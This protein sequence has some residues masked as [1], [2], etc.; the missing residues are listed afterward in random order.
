MEVG[1]IAPSNEERGVEKAMD[2][3]L[4][5]IG[6]HRKKIAKDGSC[7]FRAVAEQVLHCQSLHTEVRAKCVEFLKQNRESYEAFIE[8]DFEEYLFKLQDPQQWV[9]EVEINALAVMYKRDFLIFQEPG[10]P[11]VNITDNNF[12]DKV[13][14]CFLNGNHYD[15]VYPISHI[16]NTAV[17]QSILYELLYDGVFKVDRSF[18][19]LC[20]RTSRPTDLLSDD[21]MLACASS[22]ES[23]LDAGDALWVENGTSSASTRHGSHTYR[24]RGRG[25]QLPERVRR[26]LNP[27]LL[28]NIEYDVWQKSKRAQQKMDYCIAAGMHFSVGDRCQVRLD[29]SGRSYGATIKEVPPNNGPVTVYI[30]ELGRKHTVSLWSLRPP[31]DGGSWSTVSNRDK[32]LSNGHG[33]WEEK[34]RGRGKAPPGASSVST[35]TA[36][37]ATGRVQKQHSWPPPT[38][39]DE[40]GATKPTRKSVSSAESAFGL[41]EEQRLAKEEEK[42]NVALVEIQLRDELSFPALGTQSEGGKRKGGEKRR[43]Q[44]NKTKSPVEDVRAPS[45]KSSTPPPPTSPPPET[46][47]TNSASPG[48][49]A[50]TWLSSIKAS[51]SSQSYASAAGPAA[52]PAV[53]PPPFITPVLPPASSSSPP[54]TFIAPIA[55]PPSSAQGLPQ[56]SPSPPSVQEAPAAQSTNP[57]PKPGVTVT[58]SQTVQRQNQDTQ[59]HIA[60]NQT[61]RSQNQV[62][63]TQTSVPQTQDQNQ[64]SVHQ[65][66]NQTSVHQDQNQTSVHQDQNQTSV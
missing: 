43:S 48:D 52:K 38:S 9:G 27:T 40:Q 51:S 56:S 64:S 57:L 19:G 44:R 42:R 17:C 11:A 18:L 10:K 23:D 12:K 21:N 36:Q 61:S 28:R 5:S 29:G 66:Q 62:L 47:P 35:A 15:S 1:G 50:P 30:E 25:R 16:K 59:N 8:G 31:G 33:E 4:K 20:Q 22:D 55:P 7:L 13:R 49:C 3:Y 37:G 45:P 2:E 60:E 54:L 58:S 24:G 39:V 46:K 26:S 41:T 53:T 14:L 34:R 6:L 65:D 63:V 32:K